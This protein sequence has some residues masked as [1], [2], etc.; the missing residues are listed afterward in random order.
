MNKITLT[1]YKTANGF[2]LEHEADGVKS[3]YA[4]ECNA[5]DW[6]KLNPALQGIETM[7]TAKKARDKKSEKQDAE[8]PQGNDDGTGGK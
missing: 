8:N 5:D 3:S 7:F 4:V 6:A 2:Y 1:I